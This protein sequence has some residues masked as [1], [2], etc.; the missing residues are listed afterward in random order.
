LA[1]S[2][3]VMRLYFDLEKLDPLHDK[4]CKLACQNPELDLCY[5]RNL[6]GLNFANHF[7]CQLNQKKLDQL[8]IENNHKA[9]EI[10]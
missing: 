3:W 10:L 2:G 8:A 5:I 6:P 1:I 9:F 4:L 7:V